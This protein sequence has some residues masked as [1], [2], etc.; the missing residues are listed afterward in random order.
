MTATSQD[1]AAGAEENA[2]GLGA[3]LTI[4]KSCKSG[5]GK[6]AICGGFA[7]LSCPPGSF[8]TMPLGFCIL[9]D[10]SG[11]C[12]ELPTPCVCPLVLE[13]VCGCDGHTYDN[14]CEARCAGQAVAT[15]GT[16]A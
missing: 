7:G 9:P 16:C 11:E 1:S 3:L 14:A 2:A 13:P 4:N 12:A 8:C 10:A 6:L 5:G 15:V